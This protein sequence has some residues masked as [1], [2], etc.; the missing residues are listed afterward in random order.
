MSALQ[1]YPVQWIISK[2]TY[3]KTSN[4][5][6]PTKKPRISNN[7]RILK[8]FIT[9]KVKNWP[10]LAHKIETKNIKTCKSYLKIYNIHIL[11]K[12]S[13]E[14]K[15]DIAQYSSFHLKSSSILV[16]DNGKIHSNNTKNLN[17]KDS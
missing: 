1:I 14:I 3:R 12:K 9:L 17:D 11:C 8:F 15:Y 16:W 10:F 13:D 4:K 7:T 2:I 5:A 6:C